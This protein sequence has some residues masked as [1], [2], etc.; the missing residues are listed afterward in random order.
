MRHHQLCSIGAMRKLLAAGLLASALLP[1]AAAR[2]DH[3]KNELGE[4]YVIADGRNQQD[5]YRDGD[6]E[7]KRKWKKNGEYKEERKCKP[8]K[9]VEPVVVPVYPVAPVGPGITINGTAVIRP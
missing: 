1:L 7:I 9:Y 3:D 6:C 5:K 4:G 2:A 8:P